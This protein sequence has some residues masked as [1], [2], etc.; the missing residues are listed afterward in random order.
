MYLQ[1]QKEISPTILKDP[2]DHET[3]T[4]RKRAKITVAL[5]SQ[6]KG[7]CVEA[8]KGHFLVRI[9]ASLSNYKIFY[10]KWMFIL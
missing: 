6:K 7:R 4:V 3:Y 8:K 9:Y 2:I 5:L 10:F 1:H